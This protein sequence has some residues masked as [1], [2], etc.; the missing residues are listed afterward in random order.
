MLTR[1]TSNAHFCWYFNNY[2][3]SGDGVHPIWSPADGS[4][5]ILRRSESGFESGVT[6]DVCRDFCKDFQYLGLGN[7]VN[8]FCVNEFPTINILHDSECN[9]PCQGDP[10]TKCGG[11]YKWNVYS[12][13]FTNQF[14][15]LTPSTFIK[16][17]V[18][19]QY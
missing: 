16:N 14:D 8:C 2:F 12:Q 10:T 3:E 17:A 11:Y 6:L 4:E 18:S 1:R 5:W 15:S 13:G 9:V 7:G 19:V